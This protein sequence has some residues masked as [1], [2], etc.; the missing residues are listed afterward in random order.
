MLRWARFA[1]LYNGEGAEYYQQA[2]VEL[3]K[4]GGGCKPVQWKVLAKH[5][6]TQAR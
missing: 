1:F 5:R 4:R 2:V 3:W 6:G